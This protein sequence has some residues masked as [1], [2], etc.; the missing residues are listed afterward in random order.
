MK[1]MQLQC[2]PD[3]MQINRRKSSQVSSQGSSQGL[4]L[5]TERSWLSI[6]EL[7]V[8]K[9]SL[10]PGDL[11]GKPFQMNISDQH[12]QSSFGNRP[13]NLH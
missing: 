2:P 11:M 1:Q 12:K 6:S 10:A 4:L 8:P 9:I 5:R 3:L 7:P 13:I